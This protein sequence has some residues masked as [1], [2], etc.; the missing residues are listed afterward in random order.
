MLS[1][2]LWRHTSRAGS[3]ASYDRYAAIRTF[4]TRP[5]H[6][7]ALSVHAPLHY[8]QLRTRGSPAVNSETRSVL[9]GTRMLISTEKEAR[10]P[11]SM[12]V[13]GA[14]ASILTRFDGTLTLLAQV[15]IRIGEP[16]W[17]CA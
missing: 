15:K 2:V 8:Q 9:V 1:S 10:V 14:R 12:V 11:V 5:P 17:R 6:S 7:K 4:F 16:M 13:R 3:V